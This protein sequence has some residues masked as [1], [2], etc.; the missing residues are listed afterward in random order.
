MNQIFKFG[1]EEPPTALY[2]ERREDV[3]EEIRKR[4]KPYDV[5]VVGGGIHGAAV[6]WTAALNGLSTLLL[7]KRDFASATS[8]RSSKMLHGGLR[9]LELLDLV[10]VF[11]GI[12]AR[13]ALFQS[14]PYLARPTRFLIP[15]LQGA[16]FHKLKMKI[17]LSLYDLLLKSRDRHHRWIPREELTF[18][19][20]NP[21]RSD[22]EGCFEYCDGMISDTRMVTESLLAARQEGA[23]ALNYAEVL[24]LSHRD[25]HLVEVG[26]RDTLTGERATAQCGVVMNC[27]GPWVGSIGRISQGSI[28]ER[29]QFSRGSHLLFSVPWRDPPVFLPLPGRSRYYWIWP[30]QGHTMVGTTE[31][32]ISNVP[33]DPSPSADEVE[34]ILERVQRDAPGSGLTRETLYYGFAGIRT[35]ALRDKKGGV[36]R[37][38]RRHRW[39]YDHGVLSLVG[40]KYTTAQ[41][42]AHEGLQKAFNLADV[43]HDL[44]SVVGRAFPGA[45][46]SEEVL[47]QF[48][49]E[50]QNAQVSERVLERAYGRWGRRVA[51]I[52]TQPDWSRVFGGVVLSGEVRLSLQTELVTSLE[53]L[54]CRRLGVELLPRHGLD[55]LPEILE[56]WGTL[57]PEDDVVQLEAR[58]REYLHRHKECLGIDKA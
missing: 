14:A 45:H 24:S 30:Y 8:S 19:R 12:R 56:L 22:L 35:L 11:E 18:D 5:I 49:T 32:E 1:I 31:R 20:Y 29:I 39:E 6:A 43:K 46:C 38:S 47:K 40:G 36:A 16:W 10:Q 2:P 25:S 7:E 21:E 48:Y 15:V 53:D 23:L 27:A 58:Y 9:Y 13:E 26:W 28:A 4:R 37:Q 50:G 57:R 54:M 33:E 52:M 55:A 34:E 44:I 3:L 41:I 51:D 17:G 42:V